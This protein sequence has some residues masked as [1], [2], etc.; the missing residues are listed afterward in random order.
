MTQ[1][2]S[3]WN[4]LVHRAISLS[5]PNHLQSEL[6]NLEKVA[7]K[8]G[9]NSNI[10][11]KIVKR[12]EKEVEKPPKLINETTKKAFIRFIPKIGFKISR[13]LQAHNIKTIF[14]PPRKL[15]SLFVKHKAKQDPLRKSGIYQI[16]CECGLIYTGQTKRNF[17]KRLKEH[18]ADIRHSRES[19][20]LAQ[21]CKEKGHTPDWK[22]ACIVAQPKTKL[23][24][25]IAENVWIAQTGQLS[26]NWNEGPGLHPAWRSL[27][28]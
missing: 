10:I 16:P 22:D 20:A 6:Q 26:M 11:Q 23:Q 27:L 8:N 13:L 15:Q 7:A 2:L 9:Y 14:L 17:G 1:K 24:R 4:T 5:S 28:R 25:H 12:K 18:Q 21:H 19:T 3:V